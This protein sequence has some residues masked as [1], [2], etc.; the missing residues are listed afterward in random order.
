MKPLTSINLATVIH[1]AH[2]LTHCEIAAK[3]KVSTK[4]INERVRRIKEALN[5]RTS[6]QVV[7]TLAKAGTI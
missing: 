6:T 2:G 5:C 7:Y 4:A 1:L 3:E